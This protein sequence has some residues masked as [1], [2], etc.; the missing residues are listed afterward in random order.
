MEA[1]TSFELSQQNADIEYVMQSYFTIPDSAV[2]VT[3]S[4]I[5]AFYD[6]HK[7]IVQA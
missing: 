6:K 1:K 3:D 5:K 7:K 2:T 4:D